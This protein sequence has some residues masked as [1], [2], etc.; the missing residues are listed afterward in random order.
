MRSDPEPGREPTIL[1]PFVAREPESGRASGDAR[2]LPPW[3]SSGRDLAGSAEPA[4]E[5]ETAPEAPWTTGE[6]ESETPPWAG[7]PEPS[8]ASTE[9]F[10]AS[11]PWPGDEVDEPAATAG[12]TP[13]SDPDDDPWAAQALPG[14]P[15]PR[16]LDDSDRGPADGDEAV[17]MLDGADEEPFALEE[18]DGEASLVLNEPAVSGDEP[19]LQVDSP[20]EDAAEPWSQSGGEDEPWSTPLAEAEPAQASPWGEE[21]VLDAAEPAPEDVAPPWRPEPDRPAEELPPAA[22]SPLD[23]LVETAG[24]ALAGSGMP[25]EEAP[26]ATWPGEA[27]AWDASAAGSAALTPEPDAGEDASRVVEMAHHLERLAAD[28]RLRGADAL[29]QTSGDSLSVALAAFLAGWR[30]ARGN[31]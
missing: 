23:E 11:E 1:P 27:E 29:Q 5:A 30:A 4:D 16:I 8:E 14:E 17:L 22:P 7:A 28:L 21:G 10:T 25:W 26:L 19:W 20:R 3:S 9:P 13:S 18:T 12:W 31:G 24:Q 2:P 6:G 15:E